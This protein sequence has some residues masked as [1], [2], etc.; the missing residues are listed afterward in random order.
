MVNL[1]YF[2]KESGGQDGTVL[3]VGRPQPPLKPLPHLISLQTTTRSMLT[4]A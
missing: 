3:E 4:K 2:M 1:P